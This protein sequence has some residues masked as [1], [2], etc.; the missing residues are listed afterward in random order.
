MRKP[1]RRSLDPASR[2]PAWIATRGRTRSGRRAESSW[3]IPCSRRSRRTACRRWCGR[4][5]CPWDP[6]G[7]SSAPRATGCT[8]PKK[9]RRCFPP[10]PRG[11]R[12]VSGATRRCGG[13]TMPA[14][15]RERSCNASNATRS[16]EGKRR[17]GNRGG[18]FAVGATPGERGTRRG[19]R[20]AQPAETRICRGSTCVE[21]GRHT[22]RSRARPATI[23]TPRRINRSG[24]GNRTGPT[25]FFARRATGTRKRSH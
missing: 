14:R 17:V 15:R 20:I 1:E 13:R 16:M 12:A 21:D 22:V 24:F 3:P 25:A 9:R 4:R 23:P 8:A 11:R 18:G 2:I 10:E 6:P 19:R 5:D 7:R